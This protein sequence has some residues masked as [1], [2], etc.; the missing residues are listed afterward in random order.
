L[1]KRAFSFLFVAVLF[2]IG[3]SPLRPLIRS[4]YVEGSDVN[5]S[6][7]RSSRVLVVRGSLWQW[8]YRI[9]SF[10]STQGACIFAQRWSRQAGPASLINFALFLRKAGAGGP[11]PTLMTDPYLPLLLALFL[12]TRFSFMCISSLLARVFELVLFPV[13]CTSPACR[14]LNLRY[15]LFLSPPPKTGLTDILILFSSP[16]P[17]FFC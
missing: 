4:L 11:K 15:A 9:Q 3:L 7:F 6:L 14:V 8:K 16:P 10:P 2:C 1:R 5:T 17:F 13:F 12:N